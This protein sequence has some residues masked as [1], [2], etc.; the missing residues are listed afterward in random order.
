M[1]IGEHNR[2][3]DLQVN[4]CKTEKLSNMRASG[5]DDAVVLTP[6]I[7]MT[8]ERAIQ[9]IAEDEMVEVTP[10]NIRLRKQVLSAQ[11]RKVLGK[12]LP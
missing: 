6:V 11:D 4:P 1:V 9:F 10:S 5:K 7:L 12:R 8:L 3:Q 2:E